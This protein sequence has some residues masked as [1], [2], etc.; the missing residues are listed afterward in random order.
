MQGTARQAIL[1]QLRERLGMNRPKYQYDAKPT[2]EG[3]NKVEWHG[4]RKEILRAKPVTITT[5][6][7]P[8]KPA[9]VYYVYDKHGAPNPK[10]VNAPTAKPPPKYYR[11]GYGRY[12]AGKSVHY[13]SPPKTAK[14][15]YHAKA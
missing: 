8:Y 4:A 5:T 2:A 6:T 14:V 3:N 13:Y 7:T 10:S 1:A 11:S 9:M 15:P 12:N